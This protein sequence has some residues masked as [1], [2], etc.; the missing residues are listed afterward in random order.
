MFDIINTYFGINY[1]HKILKTF[2]FD[3]TNTNKFIIYLKRYNQLETKIL[4]KKWKF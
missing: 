3:M 4:N 2:M 1:I